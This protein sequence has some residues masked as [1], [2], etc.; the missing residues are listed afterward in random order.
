[1]AEVLGK[2]N[3]YW[4]LALFCIRRQHHQR[5]P[6]SSFIPPS[7]LEW[8]S[9]SVF[10]FCM[11]NAHGDGTWD[12]ILGVTSSKT[13]EFLLPVS[14][15][16]EDCLILLPKIWS[17]KTLSI[18]LSKHCQRHNGP[19]GWVLLTKATSLGHITSSYTNLDQTSSESRP[20]TNFKIS[21]KHQHFDKT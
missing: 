9:E 11:H 20:S 10:Y 4:A 13:C 12:G 5:Y 19:E 8:R 16:K 3:E 17:D 18:Y 6:I 1:M 7:P 21:I 15:S 14:L 2:M